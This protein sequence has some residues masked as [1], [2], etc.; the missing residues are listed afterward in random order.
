MMYP[1]MIAVENDHDGLFRKDRL[2]FMDHFASAIGSSSLR[3][4]I[5][6]HLPSMM[7]NEELQIFHSSI[8]SK[9]VYALWVTKYSVH[10]TQWIKAATEA[11]DEYVLARPEMASLSEVLS[12]RVRLL[13]MQEEGLK[14]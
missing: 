7:V 11:L 12:V 3:D 6:V 4:V 8:G 9:G 10:S 1:A 14:V 5:A 2:S 13:G